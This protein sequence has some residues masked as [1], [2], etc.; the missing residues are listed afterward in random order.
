MDMA[1]FGRHGF[2]CRSFWAILASLFIL[3]ALVRGQEQPPDSNVETD[4]AIPSPAV[5]TGHREILWAE[6]QYLLWWTKN[7][8][9]PGPLVTTTSVS[10]GTGI[11]G[12]PGTSALC[13]E[14]ELDSKLHS[15]GR[16]LF[17]GWLVSDSL[18]IEVGGL[19]LETHTTH[20]MQDTDRA[21]NPLI[22]RPF[23]NVLTGQEDAQI[24]SWPSS[25]PP[26]VGARGGINGGVFG[27]ID[28]FSDSRFWGG[29][30][31]L[32]FDLHEGADR[33]H[34]LTGFRYLGL[35]ESL[36]TSQSS[37]VDMTSTAFMARPL[38][39][40]GTP[41]PGP[42][43]VS[44]TD[45]ARTRNE[46]F[47]WQAGLRGE[48]HWGRVQFGWD[49]KVG[50]G[51]TKQ[52]VNLSGVTEWTGSNGRIGIVPAGLYFVGDNRGLYS[53]DVFACMTEAELSVGYHITPWLLFSVG[54][55]FLYWNNVARPGDQMQRG[56]D[57]RA[58]PSNL[59]Y[60]PSATNLEPLRRF[61]SSDYWAMGLVFGLGFTY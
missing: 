9:V 33:L 42:D 59:A 61:G 53:R 26:N 41:V 57:P 14:G 1:A 56:I 52:W 16:F 54:Y 30:S 31:N 23:F 27:G 39:M 58:V 28:V 21:G 51:D 22:A 4:Q 38:A 55:D 40:N 12:Q 44:M 13:G 3:P 20:F 11:L 34:F 5:T 15:G 10:G 35:E 18:G 8:P 25:F 49:A 19:I 37:T 60:D 24:V 17:G 45:R 50:L 47:G 48:W 29:E 32:V 2:V 36:R 43:I 7:Q 46:F 6:A